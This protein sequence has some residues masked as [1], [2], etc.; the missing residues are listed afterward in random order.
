MEVRPALYRRPEPE[1][2]P[3]KSRR[4]MSKRSQSRCG[5]FA[6]RRIVF[7]VRRPGVGGTMHP[8]KHDGLSP[9]N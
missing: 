6:I 8:V 1:L 9:L 5:I 2:E 3:E 4:F 7:P